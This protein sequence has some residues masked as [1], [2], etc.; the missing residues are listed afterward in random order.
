VLGSLIQLLC[1]LTKFGWLDDERFWEVVKEATNFLSQVTWHMFIRE[2][3]L[4]EHA[5]FYIL[6]PFY[7]STLHLLSV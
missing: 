2:L 7:F 6:Q 1:R 5:T 4:C 3:H